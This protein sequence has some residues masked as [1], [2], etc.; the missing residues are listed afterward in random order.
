LE[1]VKETNAVL[2]EK[3]Y[4]ENIGVLIGCHSI[5]EEINSEINK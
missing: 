3:Q 1:R 4:R 2:K 5:K